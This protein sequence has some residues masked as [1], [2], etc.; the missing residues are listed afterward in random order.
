MSKRRTQPPEQPTPVVRHRQR[1]AGQLEAAAL[2]REFDI[3]FLVGPAGTG[4]T[5]AAVNLALDA[6]RV[7][8]TRPAVELD[9]ERLGY[10]PGG[11]DEKLHPFMLPV[12]DVL[13]TQL[14]APDAAK[15]FKKFEV[16][17]L[18]F[19]RGRTLDNCVAILDEA[20]NATRAQRKTYLT[21]LGKGG[22][23]IIS[24]DPSQSDIRGGNVFI[25]EVREL[26][27][28]GI[29]G[30]VWFDQ[31]MQERSPLLAGIEKVYERLN[32]G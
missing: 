29:A 12:L 10:L 8:I 1:N 18:A 22:K 17:P 11:P 23:M 20:Q 6:E 5:H 24:G 25:E 7:V 15:T 4:K 13:R 27:D 30:V 9:G 14:G 21:R 3:L 26:V 2:F 16:C 19:I 28:A 32:H 31:S